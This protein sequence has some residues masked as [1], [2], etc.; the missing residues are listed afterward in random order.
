MSYQVLA[1]KYRPANFNE[2]V[3]QRHVLLSLERSLDANRLHHAYLFTGTRGVGKTSLA[4]LLVKCLNCEKGVSSKPC[5][6]C[7]ACVALNEGKFVD[8]IEVDAASRTK[9]EDTRDILDNVQYMPTVGRYKVYLIDEVHMLSIHSFNALLKTLEEPPEHVKFLLATTD[10]QKLPVTVLSR[11]LQ[12][13]LKNLTQFEIIKQLQVILE[14]ENIHY[15]LAALDIIAKAAN[16]SMRD[17]LSLLD[18]AINQTDQQL[19]AQSVANMLGVVEYQVVI[20]LL[21]LIIHKNTKVLFSLTQDI[22][23]N[24]GSGINVLNSLS[25][26]LYAI[27]IFQVTESIPLELFSQDEVQKFSRMLHPEYC[28]LLYQIALKSK[29]DI[30]LAPDENIGL[31]ISLLRMVAFLPEDLSTVVTK[32]TPITQVSS[33]SVDKFRRTYGDVKSEDGQPIVNQDGYD[34][35]WN[36]LVAKISLKG[37]PKQI[38]HHSLL[39]QYDGQSVIISLDE[40][41][42]NMLTEQIHHRIEKE[43]SIALAKDVQLIVEDYQNTNVKKKERTPAEIEKINKQKSLDDAYH[44]LSKDPVINEICNSFGVEIDKNEIYFKK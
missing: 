21:E 25:E 17:S 26:L 9:V 2:V 14:K 31:D 6:Q 35:N 27:Q 36:E 15:E 44:I 19:N 32:E 39:K 29:E 5:N 23:H 28:Q 10:P 7:S 8:L 42:F 43:L 13:N 4:R 40:I 20:E 30:L 38:I 16:G 18:Q 41:Y 33:V 22:I 3:G 24:G 34:L 11:C 12:F 1:R 37:V